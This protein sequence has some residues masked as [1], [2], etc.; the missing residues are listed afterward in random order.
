M[1][2]WMVFTREVRGGIGK[3]KG[4]KEGDDEGVEV[5]YSRGS[6]L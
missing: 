5:T 3:E 6:L 4:K 1:F 2:V